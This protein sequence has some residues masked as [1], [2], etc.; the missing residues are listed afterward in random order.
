MSHINGQIMGVLTYREGDGVAILIPRGPCEIETA[1]LDVTLS[2]LD[3][4]T[5]GS[6]AIPMADYAH[7]VNTGS[8]LLE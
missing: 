4:G 7:F 3:G 8:L 1:G 2:W 6:A 5:R